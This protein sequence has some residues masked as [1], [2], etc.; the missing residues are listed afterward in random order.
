MIDGSKYPYEENVALTK[1]VVD[2]AHAHVRGFTKDPS[3]RV[4]HKGT[5]L[6]ILEK[7]PY[8]TDLGVNQIELSPCYDFQ[9]V[10]NTPGAAYYPNPETNSE[11]AKP[12]KLNY[13]G[14]APGYY[15]APKASYC[16]TNDPVNEFKTL[17]KG[18]HDSCSGHRVSCQAPCPFPGS[19]EALH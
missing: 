3:S 11:S 7:L 19:S 4:K 17:V 9:E 5:F 1:K 13:W 8:I 16:G 14:Y 15:F 2:Y 6:G 10:M 18:L 12:V